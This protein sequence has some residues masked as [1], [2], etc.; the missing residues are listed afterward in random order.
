M[1]YGEEIQ[2]TILM[3]LNICIQVF[4]IL[5][6]ICWVLETKNILTFRLKKIRMW[7]FVQLVFVVIVLYYLAYNYVLMSSNWTT[8]LPTNS[9][10]FL[11]DRKANL[12]YVIAGCFVLVFP[13]TFLFILFKKNKK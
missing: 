9:L 5:G 8:N 1:W 11:V 12:D 10:E 2:R 4:S 3:I 6:V 13:L 7:K